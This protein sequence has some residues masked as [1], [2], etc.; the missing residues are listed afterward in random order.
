MRK[1]ILFFMLAIGIGG[2]YSCYQDPKPGVGQVI[3]LD[4]NEFR[5]PGAEVRFYQQG[6]TGNGYIDVTMIT[7]MHG[8][9]A[10][11][12]EPTLEVVLNV[13][14]SLGSRYGQTIIDIEPGKTVTKKVTIYP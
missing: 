7:D 1:C 13:H 11:T 3:V 8:E 14:A 6:Q 10:Y 9:C 4:A 12:H 2:S 5:V